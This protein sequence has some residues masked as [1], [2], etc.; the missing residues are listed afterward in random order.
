MTPNL[1]DVLDQSRSPAKIVLIETTYGGAGTAKSWTAHA[2][3]GAVNA[4]ARGLLRCGLKRGDACGVLSLNRSE[5]VAVYF[6]AM[7]AGVV[8]VPINWKLPAE[9]IAYIVADSRVKLMFAD[10]ERMVLAPDGVPAIGFDA[11]DWSSFLDPGDF[12]RIAPAPDEIAQILYTS[13][14]TGRPKGVPLSHAGQYWAVDT[15]SKDD[16]SAHRL[17]IA[18]PMFHMNALLNLKYAFYNNATAV[19]QPMFSAKA[20]IA[21]IEA[22]RI[23][24]L[25]AV[26]TMLAMV[27]EEVGDGP[28]P[29]AFAGVMRVYMGSSPFGQSL[30]RQVRQLFP[31]AAISNAY[32]TTE[33]GP[34]VFG[35]HPDGLPTPDLSMGYP[36]P[37]VSLRIV[38]DQG[39]VVESANSGTLQIRT[40]ALMEGYLNLPTQT[41]R[42]IRDGWYHTNDIV[43]RD[44]EGFYFFVG[45]ADDMFVS[46]GENIYPGEV[47]KIIERHPAVQQAVVVPV[48][49]E[50]KQQLPFAFVVRTVGDG[51]AR[52]TESDIK[53]WA[54]Q[55]GPAYQHPRWVEFISTMPL[56]GTNKIDRTALRRRAEDL[57]AVKPR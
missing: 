55:N 49:D 7:R 39:N 29:A 41:A 6:G 54:L 37:S 21:A 35:S 44:A 8:V 17:L 28:L 27:A 46:G 4:V 9:T 43:R 2:L 13:G 33:A 52:L 11:P 50:I 53:R 25:T 1:G 42:A 26:P 14:S 48:P 57:A 24:W 15:I 51:S 20:Y 10:A 47:E 16:V 12:A 36:L 45:R 40:P 5:F 38:D 32:G 18:A 56:A 19:L 23:T 31:N 22:H 3:D 30:L 34:A